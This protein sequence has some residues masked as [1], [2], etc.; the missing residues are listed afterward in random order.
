MCN[1][2]ELHLRDSLSS[3]ALTNAEFIQALGHCRGLKVL[4]LSDNNLC[5]P[6]GRALGKILPQFSL[7]RLDISS[8]NL[9]DDGMSALNQG[10]ESTCHIGYLDLNWNDIH[11]AGISCL[12]DSICAGKMDIKHSLRLIGNPLGL[13]GAKAVVRLLSS[14]HFL[15]EDVWLNYCKLTTCEI[16]NLHSISPHSGE[17]MTC[18]GF[19]EWVC[20]HEIKADGVKLFNLVNNFSGE[21]IH[22]LA[23][24]MHLCPQLRY[25]GCGDCNITSNGLKQLLSLLSPSNFNLEEWELHDNNLDDDGVSALIEHL[26]M[27]PYLTDIDT[28]NNSHISPEVCRNLEE[29]CEKV[30]TPVIY[31]FP[32][33]I[34][35]SIIVLWYL[36]SILIIL[37]LLWCVVY[38]LPEER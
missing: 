10:L 30:C 14:E 11:A 33:L 21:G 26:S 20:G 2:T 4:D 15:A 23:G 36:Y 28:H 31:Y 13:K 8:A 3:D 34:F 35:T 5:A 16:D 18:A 24:F 37:L 25:L 19:R 9:G 29:I 27:F 38:P 12:A 32:L 7:E 22:V 17:S 1:L 6:G